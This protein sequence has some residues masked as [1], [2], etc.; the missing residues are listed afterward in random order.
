MIKIIQDDLQREVGFKYPPD[1]IV[2]LCPSLT[3]TLFDLGLADRIVG[4]TCYCV[5]PAGLVDDVAVVGGTKD[6]EVGRV[7]DL[8]PDLVIA[9][10]EENTP[11]VVSQLAERVPVYVCDVTDY[12]SALGVI[13]NLGRIMDRESAAT[14][15]GAKIRATFTGLKPRSDCSAAYLIWKDPYMAVGPGTYIHALLER[16]GFRNCFADV[17][18]RYF[19]TALKMLRDRSPACVLLSSEPYSFD[20]SDAAE[21]AEQLPA[22][23]VITVDGEMFSWYGSRMLRAGVYLKQLMSDLEATTS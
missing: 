9:E 11:T 2:C 10:K 22:T 14:T 21:L 20:K 4:R 8:K 6:V 12:A 7:L 18:Q 23:R 13:T 1:R 15:L 17:P 19:V 5:H 3:E 16:C